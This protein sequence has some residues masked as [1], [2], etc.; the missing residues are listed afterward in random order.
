MEDCFFLLSF[1]YLFI[2]EKS[3]LHLYKCWSLNAAQDLNSTTRNCACVCMTEKNKGVEEGLEG[4]ELKSY[5]GEICV[6]GY[7]FVT[8]KSE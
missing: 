1:I 3:K 4:G 8:L 7:K 5:N 6:N 2:F